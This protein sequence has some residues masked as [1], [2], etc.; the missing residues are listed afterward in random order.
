[1]SK[2][3]ITAGWDDSPHLS[4]ATKA[5]ELERT[6]PHLRD[7]RSQ[8][9]PS[10][11][12]GSIYP[13]SASEITC[14]PFQIPPHYRRGWALDDGWNRTAAI[15]GALDP[16]ADV[17]FLTTEHYQKEGAPQMH[18]EAIKARGAWIP[19]VGDAAARTRDGVQ[20]IDI[21]RS[22]GLKIELADK[23]VEAGLYD[24][25]MRLAT[26]RLKV[27]STCLNFLA[28]YQRYHRDDKGRIVKVADH[29]MD[30]TRYLCRP[31]AIARMIAKPLPRIIGKSGGIGDRT[32]GY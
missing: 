29:L 31:T 17:M 16:D 15:W 2:A 14:Q 27:F 3:V 32:V 25:Q 22:M 6:P 20:V 24:V 28:E 13:F 12:S 18:A 26:G 30:A 23:E 5:Q 11:G 9:I 10:M 8:G 19:G 4:E 7:A 1:M 21:Y